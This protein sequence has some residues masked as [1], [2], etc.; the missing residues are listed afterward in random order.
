MAVR[1]RLSQT[2][3]PVCVRILCKRY[4]YSRQCC[5]Q[6]KAIGGWTCG[7]YYIF[8]LSEQCIMMTSSNA[9]IFRVPGLFMR[10]IRRSPVNSPHNGQW[11]GALMFSLICTWTNS[12]ANTG[13]AGDLKRHRAHYDV[14]IMHIHTPPRVSGVRIHCPPRTDMQSIPHTH[15]PLLPDITLGTARGWGY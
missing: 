12:W 1:N 9:N 5:R 15:C 2:P 6:G 14:I 10:G 11:L 3:C 4:V 8:S 13:D 7:I